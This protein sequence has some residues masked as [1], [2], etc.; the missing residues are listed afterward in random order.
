MEDECLLI[1]KKVTVYV[2][3]MHVAGVLFSFL[4]DRNV[5]LLLQTHCE[6]CGMLKGGF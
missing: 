3:L 4:I 2:A 6:P 1:I 5:L